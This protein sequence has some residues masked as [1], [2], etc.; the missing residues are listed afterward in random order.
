M[1]CHWNDDEEKDE[2]EIQRIRNELVEDSSLFGMHMRDFD[3]EAEEIW[4]QRKESNED[5]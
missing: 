2:E 4:K 5:K 1:F 3:A